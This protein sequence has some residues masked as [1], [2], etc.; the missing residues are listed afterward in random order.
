VDFTV[1]GT[2]VT[3][4]TLQTPSGNQPTYQWDGGG[5][6]WTW[7]WVYVLNLST[8]AYYGSDWVNSSAST[9]ASPYML[10]A[11][12]YRAWG[13]V[14]HPN[15]GV[16]E[17]SDPV[18]W[19]VGGGAAASV[20][21]YNNLLCGGSSFNATFTFGGQAFNATSGNWSSCDTFAPGTYSWSLNA[22]TGGCGTLTGSGTYT[23]AAGNVYNFLLDLDTPA[24]LYVVPQSG[25]CSTGTP[26]SLDT[27]SMELLQNF[28]NAEGVT[29]AK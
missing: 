12:N 28:P 26:W 24:A 15:C 11:G 29:R 20:R 4:P 27:S 9:W 19:T 3:K 10:P 16:S 2:C 25:D 22:D 7:F 5:G 14:Y 23:V 13:T 8:G 21:F 6:V 18:D 17:W 1:G